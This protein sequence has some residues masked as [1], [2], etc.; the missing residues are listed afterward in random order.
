MVNTERSH[1]SCKQWGQEWSSWTHIHYSDGPGARVEGRN[2][3]GNEGEPGMQLSSKKEGWKVSGFQ[4][5]CA[6]MFGAEGHGLC[7]W[8][9][10]III[11]IRK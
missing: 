10:Q 3:H 8:Y 6:Y 9:S 7:Y 5:L 2:S 11:R 1:C 4:E